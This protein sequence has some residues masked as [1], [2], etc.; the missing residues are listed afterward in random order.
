M[1][2]RSKA[3]GTVVAWGEN[4]DPEG[5][6]V[7]QSIVP[8][9]LTNVVA[10]G[11][12]D[13]HSLAVKADGTVVAWGDSSQGQCDVPPGLTAVAA[14]GGS[15]H[16]VALGTNGVV[17][18]WGANWSGQCNIPS[19]LSRAVAVAAGEYNTVILLATNMLPQRLL[20]PVKKGNQ[21]SAQVQT[22]YGRNYTLEFKDSLAASN[23][24]GVSTNTANGALR[25]LTD[26][27]ST[28]TQRF[29][30]LRQW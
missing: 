8:N 14:V 27:S 26:P 5:M 19:K 22:L 24:T 23:W 6:A 4:T 3:N 11:A 29:Y 13:Y 30:R 2:F 9:G 28:G 17:A 20:N 10:I 18:A 15:G 21:F 1:L 25:V 12:G 7:G 16:S